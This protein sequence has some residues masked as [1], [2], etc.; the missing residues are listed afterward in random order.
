VEVPVRE[1]E[2]VRAQLQAL[3]AWHAARRARY[4]EALTALADARTRA[5]AAARLERL[6]RQHAALLDRADAAAAE[7][8]RSSRLRAVLVGHAP[9]DLVT[10]DG[11]LDVVEHLLDLDAAV[12]VTVAEQ[13]EAVVLGVD[14]PVT[15]LPAAVADL[16][17]FA[18]RT[19]LATY[20]GDLGLAAHDLVV[21]AFPAGTA[22]E[23]VARRL[24]TLVLAAG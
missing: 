20:G 17:Q 6:A 2:L 9:T 3:D 21:P 7:R 1:A 8:R 15:Q 10:R 22:P 4:A 12:G 19:R 5:D 23:V 13:P 14:L 16:R 18:P 11:P 24:R